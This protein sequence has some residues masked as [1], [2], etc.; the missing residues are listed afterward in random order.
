M[1]ESA[2][3]TVPNAA[4]EAFADAMDLANMKMHLVRLRF[5]HQRAM[6]FPAVATAFDALSKA[7]GESVE[8]SDARRRLL[9]STGN[10]VRLRT[11]KGGR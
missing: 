11:P 8:A 5:Q 4:N 7:I 10:V 2:D 6:G 1:S 3:S 9:E